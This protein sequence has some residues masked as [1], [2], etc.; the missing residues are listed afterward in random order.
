MQERF[1]VITEHSAGA[2]VIDP[3]YLDIERS[4]KAIIIQVTLN[5]GRGAT[6]KKSFFKELADNLH[7]RVGVRREDVIINLVEVKRENWSFGNG[8]AQLA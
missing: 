7:A 5:E 3:A 1:Q 8:E 6:L 2:L 4:S